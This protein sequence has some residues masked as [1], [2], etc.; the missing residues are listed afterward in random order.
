MA[1]NPHVRNTN[2]HNGPAFFALH[3]VVTRRL[4]VLGKAALWS[5]LLTIG[6]CSTISGVVDSIGD[7]IT[8][9]KP[10]KSAVAV[11]EIPPEQRF[12]QSLRLL[13][14][15]NTEAARGELVEYLQQRPDDE[16]ASNILLQIDTPAADYFP[17]D[18]RIVRLPS[19]GSLSTLAEH[20]L[21]D[22]YQFHALAKYND[23]T[24]PGKLEQ[25]QAIKIPLTDH[26]RGAFKPSGSGAAS[27][28][29]VKIEGTASASQKAK[30]DALHREA[31][32]EF[33]AQ[34]LDNA[35]ALW[36]K[37][38]VI[39]PGYEQARLYRSQA[40]ELKEKLTQIE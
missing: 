28:S 34:N 38:L 19:G 27:T 18:Y 8:E 17:A 35:I 37:V 30:A 21:G 23:I 20:Y 6:G 7:S 39:D 16:T 29:K 4:K 24:Q 9:N 40:I 22:P 15:G 5:I 1:A 25:D 36:N 33:R 31:L 3:S 12:Q 13:E 26:A 14:Q 11:A 2:G 32:N 10:E